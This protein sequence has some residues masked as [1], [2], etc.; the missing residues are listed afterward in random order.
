MPLPGNIGPASRERGRRRPLTEKRQRS[1]FAK[2]VPP[3]GGTLPEAASERSET[4][5]APV[6]A[7]AGRGAIARTNIDGDLTIWR[8]AHVNMGETG[9]NRENIKL[10]CAYFNG[11]LINL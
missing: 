4:T 10:I 5:F 6:A 7:Q 11:D 9:W 3:Q 8:I 1:F 2:R